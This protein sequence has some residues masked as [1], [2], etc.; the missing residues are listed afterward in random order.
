MTKT[1]ALQKLKE[2]GIELVCVTE[3][4]YT[5]DQQEL[6]RKD[7]NIPDDCVVP[8]KEQYDNI[9]EL[10]GEDGLY[11]IMEEHIEHGY[12]FLWSSFENSSSAWYLSFNSGF[13]CQAYWDDLTKAYGFSLAF[14]RFTET[15]DEKKIKHIK[16]TIEGLQKKLDS[17]TS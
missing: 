14:W 1:E 13:S 12:L 10:I 3:R 5:F 17:L 9:I 11:A 16:K 8:T 4:V 2:H 6:A 7:Y 15:K